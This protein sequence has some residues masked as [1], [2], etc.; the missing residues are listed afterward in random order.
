MDLTGQTLVGKYE[1]ESLLGVGGM[2]AVW[3]ARHSL[4]G[5]KLAIKVLDE[6]YLKNEQVTRRF[7]REARVASSIQHPGIVEVLDLDQTESGVPFL[8]MEFLEGETLASR[9]ERR[10]RLQQDEIVRLGRMLLDALDAAHTHN[11]VHRDLKPENIYVVP[12]GRRGELV[13]ILD[14]GISQ[15]YEEGEHKLTMTGSVL[16]TPHYMSPEQAMGEPDVDHRADVYAAGVVL[17]ECAVGDV[18]FDA[19][20][21]NKLLRLILDSEPLPPR[22]READI[23]EAVERVILWAMEKDR[24]K[25]LASAREMYDW[26][27]RAEQGEAVPYEPRPSALAPSAPIPV[28]SGV[29]EGSGAKAAGGT[30]RPVGGLPANP[31]VRS[32]LVK[33]TAAE[34][35]P[36]EPPSSLEVDIDLEVPDEESDWSISPTLAQ[37]AKAISSAPPPSAPSSVPPP[38]DLGDDPLTPSTGRA[39][40]LELDETAL[41]ASKTPPAMQPAV[42]TSSSSGGFRAQPAVGTASSSGQYRAVSSSGSIPAPSSPGTVSAPHSIPPR[43]AELSGRFEAQEAPPPAER[44][45]W[46]RYALWGGGA[47]ALFVGLV[48]LV[49]WVVDPGVDEE[50]LTPPP[51]V[52]TPTPDAP[53]ESPRG[54]RWVSIRVEGL[55]PAATMTLDG[56][57]VTTPFRVRHGGEHVVEIRA[58]G[59]EDRR[60]E[61]DADRN[62]TLVARM[63]PAEGTIRER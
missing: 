13:K 49:R 14:F 4:T 19:P 2:G 62:R 43:V 52:N 54:P 60:I 34:W 7:G 48:F 8:V 58:D 59:Y 53:P 46:I 1:V 61:F 28:G 9:I 37:R 63:R 10:G 27:A 25:R 57:P 47:L 55:P 31:G 40:A 18:P 35:R 3:R 20:N 24:G 56:L 11:V 29:K 30:P 45:A 23:S 15:M 36:S 12:A 44:P 26:L 38:A 50:T 17:Y 22:R 42:G 6:A 33:P 39:L 16:G 51:T 32:S 41:R 21:Y 5:R